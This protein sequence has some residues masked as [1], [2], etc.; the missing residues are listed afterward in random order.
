MT[1]KDAKMTTRRSKGYKTRYIED[2]R[3]PSEGEKIVGREWL[4]GLVLLV[5]FHNDTVYVIEKMNIGVSA[6][7]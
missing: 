1:T 4:K 7:V 2:D 5:S 6:M 3:P